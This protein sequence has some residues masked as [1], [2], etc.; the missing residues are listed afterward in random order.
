MQKSLKRYDFIFFFL[1]GRVSNPVMWLAFSAVR[2]FLSLTSGSVT[3]SWVTE[4]IPS[5]V[6]IF[7]K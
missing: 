7:Q 1:E 3:L 6:A 4:N 2:I 5:F